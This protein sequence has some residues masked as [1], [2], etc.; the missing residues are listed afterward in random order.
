MITTALALRDAP[1]LPAELPAQ[2]EPQ[3]AARTPEVSANA[4]LLEREGLKIAYEL[5]SDRGGSPQ[6]Y[7]TAK[8]TFTVTDATTGAPVRGLRPLAWLTQREVGAQPPDE[9]ACKQQIRTYLGGR[10]AAQ[11]D[12]DLNKFLLLAL[13]DDNTISVINPQI[14][15]DRT[16]LLKLLT[17]SGKPE[18]WALHPDKSTLW[19]TLPGSNHVAVVE[20]AS[21]RVVTNVPVGKEPR[22]LAIAPDGKTVW[23]GHDGEGGISVVDV[24]DRRGVKTLTT[25]QGEQRIVFAEDGKTAWISSGKAGTLTAFDVAS[26]EKLSEID[27]DSHVTGLAYG[28][29]AGTVLASLRDKGE[30]A[31]IDAA[32]REVVQRVRLQTG[33]GEVAFDR[34]RRWAF[35]INPDRDTVSIVDPSGAIAPRTLDGF[36]GPDSITFSDRFAYVR[37]LRDSRV[38]LVALERLESAEEPTVVQIVAGQRAPAEAGPAALAGPI[39][40][41]PGGGAFIASPTDRA[42]LHYHEGMMAP[43]GTPQTAGRKPRAG[44]VLERSIRE[45]APGVYTTMVDLARPGT[46]DLAFLLDSPRL[47]H[48]FAQEIGGTAREIDRDVKLLTLSDVETPVAVG[49]PTV[50]RFGVEVAGADE[51]IAPHEIEVVAA[52]PP[53]TWQKRL[54][55][56][57]AADREAFEIELTPP[58]SGRYKINV[59]VPSRRAR[60]GTLPPITINAT[61]SPAKSEPQKKEEP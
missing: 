53:T 27:L 34:T 58:Q 29:L 24:E 48:C 41:A 59:A 15:F 56:R 10:I 23:V 31:V 38:T 55:V 6:A 44:M 47:S 4:Q 26:L 7:A 36:F 61:T 18:D 28:E 54:P 51:P 33:V 39:V 1:D 49:A 22:R 14:A 16:K 3:E 11:A 2:L 45:T 52:R 25:A 21:L 40:P 37:N 32:T 8:A 35:V 57:F 30:V 60:L 20:T 50:V 42:L 17:F 43:S 46:F 9:E 5:L 12:V 13:N 19:V